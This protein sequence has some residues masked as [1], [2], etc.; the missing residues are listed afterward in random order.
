MTGDMIVTSAWLVDSD[1]FGFT[2]EWQTNNAETGTVTIYL[3]QG[4]SDGRVFRCANEGLT[5]SFVRAVL[6]K[7]LDGL[8]FDDDEVV[9]FDSHYL[10]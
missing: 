7:V 4:P 6:T 10:N 9:G 3:E 1:E 2:I 8:E 5:R